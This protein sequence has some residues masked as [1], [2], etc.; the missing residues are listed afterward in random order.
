MTGSPA[1]GPTLIGEPGAILKT[2]GAATFGSGSLIARTVAVTSAGRMIE[3]MLSRYIIHL[4]AKR[5]IHLMRLDGEWTQFLPLLFGE[6]GKVG[7]RSRIEDRRSRIASS[8]LSSI[9]DPRSSILIAAPGELDLL[10]DHE[11][12][13]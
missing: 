2:A 7:R 10:L 4:S 9:L 1:I 12:E 5:F 3:T 13:H 8:V 6:W 11:P